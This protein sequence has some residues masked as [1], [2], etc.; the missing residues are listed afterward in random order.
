[1]IAL[2]LI[3]MSTCHVL[4]HGENCLLFNGVWPCWGVCFYV[5]VLLCKCVNDAANCPFAVYPMGSGISLVTACSFS[6][7]GPVAMAAPQRPAPSP[8]PPS[9]WRV[10]GQLEQGAVTCSLL[11]LQLWGERS[12]AGDTIHRQGPNKIHL[13][14]NTMSQG[15]AGHVCSPSSTSP[16]LHYMW[17]LPSRAV[18]S[19]TSEE[20]AVQTTPP[21]GLWAHIKRRQVDC[22][23]LFCVGDLHHLSHIQLCHNPLKSASFGKSMWQFC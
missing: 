6:L 23:V 10:T 14:T 7:N 2:A 11:W 21:R 22:P 8:P 17:H 1:M 16:S 20:R 3:P 9:A 5:C 13:Q 15:P 4:I 12:Q 19:D 18:S